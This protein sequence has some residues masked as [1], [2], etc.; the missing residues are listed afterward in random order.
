MKMKTRIRISIKTMLHK[1]WFL[2]CN[3]RTL[4]LAEVEP[5]MLCEV[6]CTVPRYCTLYNVQCAYITNSILSCSEQVFGLNGEKKSYNGKFRKAL[7]CCIVHIQKNRYMH[8]TRH[9]D[10]STHRCIPHSFTDRGIQI[11]PRTKV[12]R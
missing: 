12:S 4:S 10:S 2:L 9:Q 6:R 11:A 7:E 3:S 8:S 1:Y 5:Q